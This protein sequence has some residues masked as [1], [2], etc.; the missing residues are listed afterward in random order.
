MNCVHVTVSRRAFP[1]LR[2]TD[3]QKA[4]DMDSLRRNQRISMESSFQGL[5][6]IARGKFAGS[7]LIPRGA[8][9]GDDRR[10]TGVCLV[11]FL[12][13]PSER[14]TTWFFD[15]VSFRVSNGHCRRRRKGLFESPTLGG[16]GLSKRV[17][18][19]QVRTSCTTASRTEASRLFPC[20]GCVEPGAVPGCA[21]H[22]ATGHRGLFRHGLHLL[23][24][25]QLG[26]S[27][28]I[29]WKGRGGQIHH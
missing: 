24:G 18:D 4:E 25:R 14:G 10:K 22:L 2:E 16:H 15:I 26:R 12:R 1:A 7:F 28:R 11:L 20:F 27:G 17:L 21:V 13:I 3:P 6:G 29:C 19:E 8:F 23:R 5:Q 9:D